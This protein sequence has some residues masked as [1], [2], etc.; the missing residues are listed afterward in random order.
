MLCWVPDLLS[1]S[2]EQINKQSHE[3][4][5]LTSFIIICKLVPNNLDSGF[6][7]NLVFSLIF[8]RSLM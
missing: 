5:K 2:C 4:D 7:L 1:H 6:L 8:W 3:S